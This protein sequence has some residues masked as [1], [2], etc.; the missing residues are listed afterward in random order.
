MTNLIYLIL[1]IVSIIIIF[2]MLY[3]IKKLKS[4]S[5]LTSIFNV[6]F[7]LIIVWNVSLILQILF[8]KIEP[9]LFDNIAYI[10]IVFYYAYNY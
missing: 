4:K 10:S 5:Q 9:I 3:F 1:L 2:T 7:I 6:N 8:T